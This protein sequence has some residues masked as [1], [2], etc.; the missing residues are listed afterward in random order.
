MKR[1]LFLAALLTVFA[2]V[3]ALTTVGQASTAQV[4][5][6]S[7]TVAVVPGVKASNP[8]PPDGATGVET[9]LLQW[10]AG[11]TAAF[12]DVYIGTNPTLGFADFR[13]RQISTIY[14]HAPGL[15]PGTT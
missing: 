11:D 13:T 12:H 6:L 7:A 2:T 8:S 10:T 5:S 15:I 4:G 14:W 1:M 9:P 3:S